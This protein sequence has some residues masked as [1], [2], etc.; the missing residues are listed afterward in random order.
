MFCGINL[1][2]SA[3]IFYHSGFQHVT[4]L[5]S[6]PLFHKSLCSAASK[7]AYSEICKDPIPATLQSKIEPIFDKVSDK[8]FSESCKSNLRYN[9]NESCETF[10][11]ILL[12]N[13]VFVELKKF[14]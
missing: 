5:Q 1:Q 9:P 11:A 7:F 2:T 3:H 10:F 8:I 14:N 4:N 6:L 13:I 12:Q